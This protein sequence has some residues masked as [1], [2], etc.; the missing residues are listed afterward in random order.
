MCIGVDTYGCGAGTEP[1][2]PMFGRRECLQFSGGEEAQKKGEHS[3]PPVLL[4]KVIDRQNMNLTTIWTRR[5]ETA[6]P[7]NEP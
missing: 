1:G 7:W 4:K 6:E 5:P 2:E 3:A